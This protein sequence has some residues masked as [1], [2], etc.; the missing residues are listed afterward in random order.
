VENVNKRKEHLESLL[1]VIEKCD[2]FNDDNFKKLHVI[3]EDEI[4]R[5]TARLSDLRKNTYLH[6]L[7]KTLEKQVVDYK[8]AIPNYKHVEYFRFLKAIKEDLTD[9][10]F[11]MKKYA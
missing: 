8:E 2:I 10:L 5:E 11:R 3:I 7:K 9:E 4:A 1:A 6:N